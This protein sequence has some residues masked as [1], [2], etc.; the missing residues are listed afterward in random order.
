MVLG[1]ITDRGLGRTK[2]V[3]GLVALLTGGWV[4]QKGCGAWLHY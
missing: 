4:G 1:C 2:G 3:W